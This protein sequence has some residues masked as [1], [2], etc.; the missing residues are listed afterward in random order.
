LS[1]RL[2]TVFVCG[3]LGVAA[4]HFPRAAHVVRAGFDG[5]YRDDSAVS[6]AAPESPLVA[7]EDGGAPGVRAGM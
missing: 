4:L 1:A 7:L 6:Q 2:R 3:C 5:P